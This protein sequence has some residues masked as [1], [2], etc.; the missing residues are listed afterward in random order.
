M[1]YMVW[2]LIK[3]A[4]QR[5]QPH[6][7]WIFQDGVIT[8][9]LKT[10][11]KTNSHAETAQKPI[12][13][14]SVHIAYPFVFFSCLY[15]SRRAVPS[16][17]IHVLLSKRRLLIIEIQNPPFVQLCANKYWEWSLPLCS[18]D[19]PSWDLQKRRLHP[20]PIGTPTPFEVYLD[21]L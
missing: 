15:L 6:V 10:A 16:I 5:N 4:F 20:L 18:C 17:N 11:Q 7:F 19:F 14:K 21:W 2:N 1:L 8:K 9:T 13:W 3:L 12:S